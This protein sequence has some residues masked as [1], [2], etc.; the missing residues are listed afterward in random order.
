MGQIRS[1][2]FL[3]PGLIAVD[4]DWEMTGVV[5]NGTPVPHRKGLLDW[6]MAKQ[7]DGSWLIEIMHNAEL[8]NAPPVKK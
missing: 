1:I 8:T 5:R 6:V 2:R 3:T 4:V 7:A